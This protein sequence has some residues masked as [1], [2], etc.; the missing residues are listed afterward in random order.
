MA[1]AFGY[2]LHGRACGVV[3]G[4]DGLLDVSEARLG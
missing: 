2:L 1:P 4:G 3:A